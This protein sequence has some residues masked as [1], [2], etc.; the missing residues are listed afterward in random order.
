MGPK[1]DFKERAASSFMEYVLILGV[2]SAVLIGM[3]T[4]IKRGIQGR[5]K[6]MTDY[7]IVGDLEPEEK[8]LA[9][10]NPTVSQTDTISNATINN[11]G[12]IGGGI[13]QVLLETKDIESTSTVED[14]TSPF[15]TPVTPSGEGG[16]TPP[17]P[18][19]S[20]PPETEPPEGGS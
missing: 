17:P 4:Y 14:I 15:Q 19:E 13:R 2:V 9:V 16:I 1:T 8:Q 6:E 3:N 10:L 20:P 11:A 5:L 7:F 12:F 18:P